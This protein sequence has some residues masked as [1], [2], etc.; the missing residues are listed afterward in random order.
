[1]HERFIRLNIVKEDHTPKAKEIWSTKAISQSNSNKKSR[2][3]VMT[4]YSSTPNLYQLEPLHS[5]GATG[6]G[7]NTARSLVQKKWS[8]T[9]HSNVRLSV[10]AAH[11]KIEIEKKVLQADHTEAWSE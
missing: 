2:N 10:V 6:S 1:M 8:F 3:K 9:H 5:F 11:N 7:W 4:K